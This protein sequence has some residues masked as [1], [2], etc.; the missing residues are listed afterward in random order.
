MGPLNFTE[1]DKQKVTQY[2]NMV[3]KHAKFEL[4]TQELIEY[5]KLLSHMQQKIMP[6]LDANILEITK[7]VENKDTQT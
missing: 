6:K 3:A 1:E 5:F 7:V 4:N 2:L